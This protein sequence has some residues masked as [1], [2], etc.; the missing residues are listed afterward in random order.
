MEITTINLVY[1]SATYTTQKIVREIAQQI[2]WNITEYDITNREPSDDVI[3]NNPNELL[4]VGVPV[5]AGR[6]PSIAIDA[7]NKFKGSDT[8]AIVICTYG[9]RAYDDALLELENLVEAN[10]FKTIAAGAFIAKH[11]IFPNVAATRPDSEDIKKAT[12]FGHH[13]MQILSTLNDLAT[14][15]KLKVSGNKPYKIPKSIP[16]HPTGNK[17]KCNECGA[18]AK[19]CPVQAIPQNKLHTTDIKKCISCGRCIVV[20]P[21]KARNFNGLLYKIAKWKFS[22]DNSARKEP[23]Y[24]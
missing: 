15:P 24:F 13:C 7:L 4:I 19:L 9:N 12:D 16:I 1:F 20:C 5:Y 18:C 17:N 8:P 22:K 23:E 21:Q 3:L 11:S 14:L 2:T 10:G 6:I